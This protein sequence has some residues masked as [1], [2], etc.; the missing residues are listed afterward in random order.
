MNFK[1]TTWLSVCLFMQAIALPGFSGSTGDNIDVC[2]P[3]IIAQ[4]QQGKSSKSDV[5][6]LIGEPQKVENSVNDGELWKYVYSATLHQGR[7]SGATFGASGRSNT[8]GSGVISPAKKNCSVYVIFER[9]G[10]VKKVHKSK[11]SSGSGFLN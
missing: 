9:N 3:K 6:Q 5:K 1:Y 11:I 8:I 4:I 2:D 7:S 10:I